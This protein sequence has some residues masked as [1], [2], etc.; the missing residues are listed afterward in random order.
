MIIDGWINFVYTAQ[1]L[2][3]KPAGVPS[4]WLQ[5]P[6]VSLSEAIFKLWDSA[7]ENLPRFVDYLKQS[8][9]SLTV[10]EGSINSVLI[11]H[12]YENSEYARSSIRS[13]S[14]IIK[15]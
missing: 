11:Y 14:R 7:S 2:E 4:H 5:I 8:T 12:L 13:F 9:L 10:G 3:Q 6:D 1:Q 15:Y